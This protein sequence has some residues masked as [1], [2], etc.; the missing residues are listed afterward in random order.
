MSLAQAA[1]ALLDAYAG[2]FP[3]H[4]AGELA[5]LAQELAAIEA[6]PIGPHVAIIEHLRA[7]ELHARRIGDPRLFRRL[8]DA[9]EATQAH[10]GRLALE[11]RAE[12]EREGQRLAE[13]ADPAPSQKVGK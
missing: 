2:E 3:D 13:L 11:W 9:V 7:V 10:A 5:Q 12:L 4:L 6:E 8:R 1:R